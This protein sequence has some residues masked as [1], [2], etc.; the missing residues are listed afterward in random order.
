MREQILS[1]D[2]IADL[3]ELAEECQRARQVERDLLA[4]LRVAREESS[5]DYLRG[6][7]DAFEE[8]AQIVEDSDS[9]LSRQELAI[10]LR[11]LE[12]RKP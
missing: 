6:Q 3:L 1:D 2:D 7:R 9:S 5:D 8:A 10:L 12:N 11:Q 4:V